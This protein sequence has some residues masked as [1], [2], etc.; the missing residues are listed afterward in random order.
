MTV[1]TVQD[2]ELPAETTRPYA[3]RPVAAVAAATAALLVAIAGRGGYMADELYFIAAGHRPSWGYADQPPLVPLLARM[4]DAVGGGSV[5]VL[6]LPV[7]VTAAAAVL[8]SA[9]I[10]REFG[11]GRRA[12]VLAAVAQALAPVALALGH[13]LATYTIDPVLWAVAFWLLVR[14]LRQNAAGRPDDRLLLALGLVI[15][16]D[17]QVKY[18]IGGLLAVLAVS[19]LAVGPRRLLTRPLLWAGAAIVAVTM[20]PGVVWQ[21]RNGWPQ[22]EMTKVLGAGAKIIGEP[23]WFVP[24]AIIG[25][26]IP[27]AVLG[28][29]GVWRL[30]RGPEL[31]PYRCAGWAVVGTTL[32]FAVT[33]GSFLY[34]MGLY[35]V[36][37]AAGAAEFERRT[38]ARWWRWIPTWPVCAISAVL[39]VVGT[40]LPST[41][42][43][44]GA[45]TALSGG[46]PNLVA[47]T[48]RVY[49]SL[50]AAER[51]H[52]AIVADMYFQ[53]AAV[54]RFGP[55]DGLP[56]RAYSP[57]RGFWYF[58]PP[59]S[60]TTTVVYVGGSPAPLRR[61]FGEVRTAA[62]AP[63]TPNG[64]AGTNKNVP[65]RVCTAPRAAW[66]ALWS[67][68]YRLF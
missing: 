50:P 35:A 1:P 17:V 27:G 59:P 8:V 42:S 49:R 15:A 65:I 64:A 16:V 13:Y 9:A 26:G 55:R 53:A 51:A 14:W 10:A 22:L 28:C 45:N 32:L 7:A 34:A 33:G 40:V 3:W 63:G 39:T 46:W 19:V 38:V 4:M 18:L 62:T 47:T 43:P 57:N 25:A 56:A 44:G 6:R 61:A 68:M 21:A 29:Y 66:P 5:V 58:G 36:C 11:G 48:A 52:T 20:A 31:R 2:R 24:A 30:L 67:R 41:A 60:G 12:Q 54:E 37:W 23:Y